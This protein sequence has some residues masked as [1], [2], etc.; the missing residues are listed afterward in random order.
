[1]SGGYDIG[2][3]IGI[4]GEAEFRKQ[5]AAIT[6]GLKTMGSEMKVVTTQFIGQ[7]N[8][9][10]ALTAQN[11]VL[12]R[13]IYS[14]N[15]KLDLQKKMLQES[16]AA[17]GEADVRTQKWQQAV[18]KTQAEINTANAQI[19]ENT[20]A[21]EDNG[22]EVEETAEKHESAFSRMAGAAKAGA[23]AIGAALTA[24]SAAV[25]ALVKEALGAYGDYEQLVGG[26]ETLFGAGGQSLEEYAAAQGKT[27]AEVEK[28]YDRLI[29]A[30]E[31]VL[32]NA[33]NAY[34]TAGLSANEYMETVTSVSA[35]LINSLGG[36]TVKAAEVADLA[37]TD[38]ADNANKM[39]SS[40]ESI[41]NAY[42]GFAK[43]QYTMLDNLKLGYGG[44]KTEMERLLKDAEKLT[45]KKF[46]LDNYADIVEAIHA[47]QT[48]MG[49]T[50]TTAR[51]ASATLQ[52]S[53]AAMASAWKNLIA[54]MGDENADLDQLIDNLVDSV[55]TM[56]D[57]VVPRIGK[58]LG[59]M[60]AGIE[61][62]APVISE[63]LPEV[64]G[65][66]LPS[67]LEAGAQLVKGLASGLTKALPVLITSGAEIMGELVGA[68]LELLPDLITT[69][70][71][72][73]NTL[74][75]GLVE[76]LPT[77]VPSALAMILELVETLLDNVDDLIDPAVE[78]IVA[79][80]EGLISALPVLLQKTPVIISKLVTALIDAAPKLVDAALSIIG[81]LVTG[82]IDNLPQIGHAAGELVATF[83]TAI[84][85]LV[86]TLWNVGG[87]IV[88][89]VWEGIKGKASWFMEKVTGFFSSIV[90]GV[91]DVLGIH[92]P[93]RVFA[94]IGSNMAQGLGRGWEKE[95]ASIKRDIENGL[96]FDTSGVAA[97][98]S[99]P[100]ITA[101][102][103]Q[104]DM[105]ELM[106]GMVNGVQTAMAGGGN[107]LPQSATIILQTPDGTTVARWLLPDFRAAMRDDPEAV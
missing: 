82:L 63:M 23:A 37:I 43:G 39:G 18:N 10:K 25:G 34:K 20:A 64:L 88:S 12:Q 46:D 8:S 45:G 78:I 73:I 52:G 67:L 44:T 101:T 93:S 28:E 98:L 103:A 104:P 80:A 49:I 106:A 95:Y 31:G 13:T 56:L 75:S 14:L 91:K 90:D 2:P 94:G 74:A 48:E 86:G 54:G 24:A 5:I 1:M 41:Q 35:A 42:A 9:E 33:N 7:E 99:M 96:D 17:Y 16:A 105:S 6:T 32:S 89:G 21:L 85:E 38:M 51:E 61:Q 71:E 40:M 15:E 22:E 58:I 77:L 62:L 92:S 102:M 72:I 100:G 70:V 60:G 4:D 29:T 11:D 65:E 68:V 27:V 57:N 59:G 19:A 36:D 66:V 83:G 69:A 76:N 84:L 53:T 47:I 97:N 55:V 26:V 3:R 79:L 87:Q 81:T 50:G 30:Q 107:D